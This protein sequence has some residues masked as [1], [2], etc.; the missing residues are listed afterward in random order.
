M[1]DGVSIR[2]HWLA[3]FMTYGEWPAEEIDHIDGNPGNN[4]IHN[5][6]QANSAQNKQNQRKSRKGGSSKYLGVSWKSRLGK[7]VAQISA[8]GKARYLGLFQSEEAAHFA[9]VQA[10]REMH[11]HNTL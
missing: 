2:A 9:Y 5:L 7:W 1:V 6:R 8:N 10:K 11:S 4:A 3:W